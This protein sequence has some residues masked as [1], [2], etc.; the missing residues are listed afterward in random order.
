MLAS[1]GK[2]NLG[3]GKPW[4]IYIK[5]LVSK[6]PKEDLAPVHS[7]ERCPFIFPTGRCEKFKATAARIC[8]LGRS[9]TRPHEDITISLSSTYTPPSR[10]PPT[11]LR[12]AWYDCAIDRSATAWAAWQHK[13]LGCRVLWGRDRRNEASWCGVA[14]HFG[15]LI[16]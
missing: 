8:M 16:A 4:P 3:T 7:H 15:L 10:S 6:F 1:I 9:A 12:L 5:N 14:I 13:E 2:T 11:P